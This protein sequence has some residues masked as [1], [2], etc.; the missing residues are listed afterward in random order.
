MALNKESNKVTQWQNSKRGNQSNSLLSFIPVSKVTLARVR[1]FFNPY[2]PI[3]ILFW[4]I[5]VET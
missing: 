2:F 1:T 3:N 5:C 4:T